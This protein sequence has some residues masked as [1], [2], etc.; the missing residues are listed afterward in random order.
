MTRSRIT[1]AITGLGLAGLLALT[2]CGAPAAAADPADEAYALTSVDLDQPAPSSSAQ[3]K[4]RA[5]KKGYLRRNTLHGEIVVQGKDGPRTIVVQRGT[6]TATDEKTIS[7][8]SIDGFTQTWTRGEKI[9]VRGEVKT[10]AEVGVAGR[11]DG[12]QAVARLVVV[13]KK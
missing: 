12:G 1:I 6:V 10:G 5:G 4:N 8:K 13:K 11:E 9:T 7:V 2:G 3:E